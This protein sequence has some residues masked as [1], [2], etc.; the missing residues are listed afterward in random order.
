MEQNSE[1][2]FMLL[3]YSRL[4]DRLTDAQ[5]RIVLLESENKR[6]ADELR[7]AIENAR[8]KDN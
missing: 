6:L 8:P 1:A 5:K 3:V 4:C 7:V 2:S